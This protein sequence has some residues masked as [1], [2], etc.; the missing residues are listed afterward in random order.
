LPQKRDG[1][2]GGKETLN[3]E[4]V[5][6]MGRFQLQ[7]GWEKRKADLGRRRRGRKNLKPFIRKTMQ[8]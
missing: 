3:K 5:A 7:S 4:T 1:R 8:I 2:M 6:R